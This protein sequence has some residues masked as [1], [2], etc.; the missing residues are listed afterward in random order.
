MAKLDKKPIEE[1]INTLPKAKKSVA[2]GLL[3]KALFMD[4][5]L[6]KLQKVL[7]EKGWVEEYQNGANQCGLKKSSEADVYNGMIKNYNSTLKQI[8]DLFPAE[9]KSESGD[10]LMS[11]LK[12]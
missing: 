1:L 10:P 9:N 7:K 4:E 12:K 3:D 6:G 11:F 8:A 2:L 5:E